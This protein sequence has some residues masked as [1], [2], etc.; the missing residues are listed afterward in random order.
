ML[1]QRAQTTNPKHENHN[2]LPLQTCKL[3]LN[4]CNFP[5]INSCKPPR[6]QS[7]CFSFALT[8]QTRPPNWSYWWTRTPNTWEL[9]RL[10]RCTSPVRPMPPGKLP[11][12]KNSSKPLGNLLNAC[13]K[14]NHAQTSP[15]CW[16]CTNQAKNAK[17]TK[18]NKGCYTCPNE[19]VRYSIAS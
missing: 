5:W 10:D 6:N 15:T 19:Q 18:L 14:P 9:H 8:G 12:L 4:Q 11:E 17:N 16:Q 3:P 1:K 2:E 13:S 7:S